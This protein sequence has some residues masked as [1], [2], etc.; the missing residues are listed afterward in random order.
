MS[1]F[2]KDLLE[3]IY[4]T[5]GTIMTIMGSLLEGAYLSYVHF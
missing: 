4:G 3:S 2:K 1:I 5:M